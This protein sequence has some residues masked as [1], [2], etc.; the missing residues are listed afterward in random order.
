[1]F[2]D[3]DLAVCVEN[4]WK[5]YGHWWKSIT[6]LHG[7][8][9]NVPTG[10]IYG[11]L[12]PSGCGKTT[13][14]RC[15]VGRLELNQGEIIVFGKR[16][17]T[18]GHEIPGR[19]VGYMPQETALY[20]NFSISEM[21]HY[22]GRLHNM[23]RREILSREEFL[24]SF[25]DL[26][27][28]TKRV[29]QLSGGQQRRVSLACA[30]LQQ[31]QLLI[32]DEPTVGVDPLLREKIWSHLIYLSQTSKTTIMI[33]THYIEEARK[34]NRVG[35][36]RSGRILAEDEPNHLLN[37]Y[38]ETSLENVFLQLCY[39]DQN[40][41]QQQ[42]TMNNNNGDRDIDVSNNIGD[43]N[44][45]STYIADTDVESLL[46][47]VNRK[48]NS[49]K[50]FIDYFKFPHIHK[51]YALIMKDLTLVKRN[52]SLLIFQFLIPVIQISLFCLCI[53]R[54]VEHISMALYN[55]EAVN[56][57][58]TGNLSLQL[59][60]KIN[61]QQIDITPYNDFNKSMDLVKQGQ[62]WGV[63]AIQDNFTQAVKNKLIEL[64][65]DPATL[66]ASSL[67][68]Y[69]DMTNQQVLLT[70]QNALIN[71]TGV[72]LKEILSSVGIDPS[73]AD[74]PIIIE[75]PVYGSLAPKFVNFAAPGMMISIIFFL[76]IGLTGLIFV[77]EKKE[78]LLERTWITG[79]TTIEVMLAHISVKFFIQ[80]IQ[81][82]LLLTFTHYIFKIEIK[83]S[84]FLAAGIIF[85][86]GIC[87][88]SYGFLIS[89]LCDEEMEAMQ[90]ALG[91]VFPVLICSGI[92]WPLEGMPSIMRFIS[93]FTPLTH[94][95]EAMRCIA[96]R[97]WS[98]THF[99]VWLG[100]VNASSWSL[101]FFII[102]AIIFAL[103]K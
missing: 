31:P 18:H 38:N 57:F 101:G 92:I 90:V 25:L 73:V 15:I 37:Q 94:T 98:L 28:K 10:I 84:I 80:I 36:M 45:E 79:V 96:A 44:L 41:I 40:R 4:A 30:L 70:M 75:N 78:G 91:S 103:R 9:V 76:A 24:I 77:I 67:H 53:G 47:T 8:N 42:T 72:F 74:P 22:F 46:I 82:I 83:G 43:Q 54:D 12:G 102:A 27:S 58:P 17:G 32:L 71:S 66:N 29:S 26:P 89:S 23:K 99:K 3:A 19:A 64:Q 55:G 52:I 14:L 69:L 63:I 21:L 39:E 93:N 65:T 34:A 61:P 11:L 1:M 2:D 6:I 95:V 35:L 49:R 51:I 16:P 68:L 48:E 20:R 60:N 13:L 87:G 56:G 50:T 7:V 85:L 81:V 59:L 86:Q 88:M 100:F 33:T 62:H 5:K 97:S